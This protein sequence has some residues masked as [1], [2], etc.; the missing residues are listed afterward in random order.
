MKGL[1]FPEGVL[2]PVLFV[3]YPE[4]MKKIVIAE[5]H[6]FCAGVTRAIALAEKALAG[7]TDFSRPLYCLH[8]LVHNR[9][10]VERLSGRG[11]VFVKTLDEVPDGETVL[12]SAH[13][14]SPAIREAAAAKGLG[15]IDATCVFVSKVHE[16][17]RKYAA[18]GC[19]VLLIGNRGHDEVLG[20]SGEAPEAV[21]VVETPAD[22]ES[23]VVSNPEKVAVV[24]QTTLAA[25]QVA[26]VMDVLRR[27]FPKLITPPRSG[28]CYATTDRQEAVRR[29]AREAGF[30]LVLGSRNSANSN[31]LVDVA[32]SEGAQS[33][34]VPDVEA[35][36]DLA[37]E[38]ALDGV[39]TI[40][41]TAGAST[42]EDI[43]ASTVEFLKTQGFQQ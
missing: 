11:I 43:V 15:V 39:E 34:L 42:P 31:R 3:F 20:V 23:V 27:R 25:A 38:G 21:T 22:A 14:V 7:R 40:G 2:T 12:F 32:R 4:S 1:R 13:G 9:H 17:V 24:T 37:S 8:E 26:T 5:P 29:V 35:V 18:E 6:G 30:V 28:I 19:S 41:L 36:G 33:E 10:V 16:A